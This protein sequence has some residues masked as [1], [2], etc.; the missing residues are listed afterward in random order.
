MKKLLS[1]ILA[2]CLMTG[3]FPVSVLADDGPTIAYW[4]EDLFTVTVPSGDDLIFD[5][6][7]KGVTVTP[8]KDDL[9][10]EGIKI[11]Y[12]KDGKEVTPVDP[13]TYST[14]ISMAQTGNYDAIPEE[15]HDAWDFTIVP[16]PVT[17]TGL[18]VSKE[19]DGTTEAI[20]SFEGEATLSGVLDACPVRLGGALTAAVFD[21]ADIGDNKTVTLTGLKLEPD[22]DGDRDFSSC[23]TLSSTIPGKIT[24]IP[25]TITA[26]NQ[27]V[28]LGAEIVR[29]PDQVEVNGLR[30]GHTLSSI[31]LIASDTGTPTTSGTI[32]PV[33][34]KIVE[35]NN[36]TNEVTSIYAITYV[37]GVL[38]VNAPSGPIERLVT[39]QVEH[40]FWNDGTTKEKSFTLTGENGEEPMLAAENIP[41]VGSNPDQGFKA[42]SWDPVP[43]AGDAP[44]EDKI[45]IYTYAQKE[46]IAATVTFHVENGAWDDGT[47]DDIEVQLTGFENDPLKLADG[48]IPAVGSKPTDG[49]KAGSWDKTPSTETNFEVS[50][51][52]TYTYTYAQKQNISATVTFHVDNGSWDDGTT[53]NKTVTL[54]GLEGDTLKLADGDI[55]TVGTKPGAEYK[56]GGWDKTPSTDTAFA[57][58]STTTYTYTYAPKESITATVTFHVANG[59]WDDGTTADKTVTLTGLEGDTLK[60]ADGDIPAVGTKPGAEYKAGGWDK[61]PSTDTAFADKSTTTYT[62]TYAPK[63]SITATVLFHVANGTWDDESTAE[64]S[65]TLTGYEG[66]SLKLADSD[67]P[68]VGSKPNDKYKA[69]SWDET[70][71]TDTP[72]TAGTT[73]NYTYTYA[74]RQKISATVIFHVDNGTW[75]DGSATD[76]TVLL[77]GLE[78]DPLQ[79]ADGDIPA[80]G[81]KP[82]DGYK[83]GSWD[84]TPSTGT[85]FTAGSTTT[86]TYTYAQ[87]QKIS[88]TVTFRV[89]N[90]SWNTGEGEAATE[91][92]PVTLT[93]LENEPLKLAADQIPA[94]GNNPNEGY[95][96]GS[97]D[98]LPAADKA[99]EAGTTTTY[100]YTYIPEGNISA[101]VTFKVVNGTWD[102]GTIADKSFLLT[103]PESATLL[104]PAGIIPAAGTKPGKEYKAGSWDTQPAADM[105]ITKDTAFTYTY[106]AR[107]I[108]SATVTF[109]IVNGA[110]DGANNDKLD[111]TFVIT[112]FEGNILMASDD[113]IPA[114]GSNPDEGYSSG[115]WNKNPKG[116]I[117]APGGTYVYTYSYHRDVLPINE[118]GTLVIRGL[119]ESYDYTSVAL[120]PYFYVVDTTRNVILSLGTDY[121]V[122]YQNNKKV[123]QATII[124]KGKGNYTGKNATATFEIKDPYARK[125]EESGLDD[126]VD[127]VKKVKAGEKLVY[128]GLPQYPNTITVTL[129]DKSTITL[130]HEG[131]GEYSSSSDKTVIISFCNNVN[132]GTAT[133]AVTGAD[134]KW[135]KATFKIV[136]ADFGT[137]I[138][139]DNLETIYTVKGN[140]KPDGFEVTWVN[141][142]DKE[143]ELLEGQ[144][145]K[146]TFK[147]DKSSGN[148]N[149]K[150]TGKGN[151]KGKKDGTIH[152]TAFEPKGIDAV[153]AYDGIK[154]KN[155]KI[156]ILDPV[157]VALNMAKMLSVQVKDEDGNPL[158]D[159]R[160]LK[161]GEKI[162]VVVK[163]KNSKVDIPEDGL[164]ETVKIGANIGKAKIDAK[165]LTVTYTGEPI[166]LTAEDMGNVIITHGK[167]ANAVTLAYGVD[168]EIAGY[169]NN[170]KKGTMTVTLRG[171]DP[172]SGFKTFKVKILP[173]NIQ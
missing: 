23:Y 91:N 128:N 65:V 153:C 152:A 165:K 25:V 55:P 33:N 173:Q 68:A 120:K 3:L 81:T 123:G 73:T 149:F 9:S 127:A 92:K 89:V 31:G 12:K 28:E 106:E 113:Q 82:S 87:R 130:T 74:Q 145:F 51:A 62:Y 154:V 52:T 138:L 172:Y 30:T 169:T 56:V 131:N 19:Y 108:I 79:L 143:V 107:K 45:Y 6:R 137:A 110:W 141:G 147:T 8:K 90:G 124:V 78:N 117:L 16:A 66:D 32:Q 83:A 39:F 75:D 156:I 72:F 170:I 160:E 37:N 96:A 161:A 60:L 105:E 67:I 20:N 77:E 93:A 34:A 53:E 119:E 104:L 43:V 166:E 69:G 15:T 50:S 142:D 129:A 36:T 29:N 99:F 146:A 13:G 71:P 61:T 35:T 57:D 168:F 38:T 151:F 48:Q 49:Y 80:V 125:K 135:K 132:K 4:I 116:I 24:G 7:T 17:I 27:T 59:T 148:I 155:I 134:G 41:A 26:K 118:S 109:R 5:G 63:E 85:T 162:T 171:I 158:D 164:E 70:P 47:T 11:V 112:G 163:S 98:T 103:G 40:G 84:E 14:H 64:K 167:K 97:W 95:K 121:T 2:I 1:L 42:G 157:G 44:G 133:V 76:K 21:N 126:V 150:L 22:P 101:T 58:K 88:A 140:S 139:P 46:S 136:V 111:R 114:A 102:D 159:N 94:A 115:R 18:T 100:T 10:T 86:Y 54:T 122:K 144:D